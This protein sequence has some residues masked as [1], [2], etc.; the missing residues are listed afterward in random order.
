M[1]SFPVR[2]RGLLKQVNKPFPSTGLWRTVDFALGAYGLDT[3]T[4][5]ADAELI[6]SQTN[7]LYDDVIANDS[8]HWYAY[9]QERI[10]FLYS[11]TSDF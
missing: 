7:G 3:S 2:K 1:A 6:A 8:F 5:L 10:L 11:S 4:A 9:L